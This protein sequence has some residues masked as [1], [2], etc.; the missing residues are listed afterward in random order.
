MISLEVYPQQGLRLEQERQ[1]WVSVIKSENRTSLDEDLAP[2]SGW[3]YILLLGDALPSGFHH[4]PGFY[5]CLCL[6]C[7]VWS[8]K[9]LPSS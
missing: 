4:A 9:I 2:H 6:F 5:L 8:V 7:A 3:F 1:A